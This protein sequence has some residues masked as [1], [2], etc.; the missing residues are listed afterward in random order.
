MTLEN[1]PRRGCAGDFH[2]PP[3]G[4][5]RGAALEGHLGLSRDRGSGF[6]GTPF[7]PLPLAPFALRG[8]PGPLSSTPP[9]PPAEMGGWLCVG[10][11]CQGSGDSPARGLASCP[12]PG[13]ASAELL[14]SW[15]GAKVSTSASGLGL[16]TLGF[17]GTVR[18]WEF[19]RQ[20]FLYILDSFW[21]F[22]SGKKWKKNLFFSP[23]SSI[24][25]LCEV[26]LPCAFFVL[27]L[28]LFKDGG[29]QAW[30]P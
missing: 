7:P 20:T 1:F 5:R 16:L 10:G 25:I 30:R 8:V 15:G 29:S 2:S 22:L 27:D 9:P 12:L 18:C 3:R 14:C 13:L 17:R 23:F 24:C 19:G 28:D 21:G 6:R 4:L 26:C 11:G